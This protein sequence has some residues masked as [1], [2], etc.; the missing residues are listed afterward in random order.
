MALCSLDVLDLSGFEDCVIGEGISEVFRTYFRC[1]GT[2][3]VELERLC[4]NE[5]ECRGPSKL[6]CRIDES[7]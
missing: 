2:R 7:G 4:L 1:H 3:L 6:G 5:A